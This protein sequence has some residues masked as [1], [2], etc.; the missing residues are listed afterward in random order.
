[1]QN[2]VVV[3]DWPR[4][5][6]EPTNGTA[7]LL[8]V[9]VGD[10]PET[11]SV[12]RARHHVD[13]LEPE[14]LVVSKHARADDP[15]WFDAWLTGPMSAGLDETLGP[16][17]AADVRGARRMSVVRGAFPDSP[18]LAYLRNAVGIVSAIAEAGGVAVFDANALTWWRPG[19]WHARF[20]EQS[21]FRVTD[22]VF[23][24]VTDD[25]SRRPG[26]W[27]HTRGMRKFARPELHAQHLPGAYDVTNPAIRDSGDVLAGLATHLALGAV[28]PTGHVMHLPA[29]DARLTFF[30]DADPQTLRYFSNAA[31]EV[32]DVDPATGLS[33]PGIARLLDAMD[34]R[35]G[36]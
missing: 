30:G 21:R 33:S 34:V 5:H 15:A 1:M 10:P 17:L 16:S 9:V 27:T 28:I 35:R 32:C 19:D 3:P 13:S 18:S 6:H 20:V 25:P 24:A 2:E 29:W 22:H 14:H 26:L 11:L 4:P 36:T 31:L 12:K 23:I 8:Y 7:E